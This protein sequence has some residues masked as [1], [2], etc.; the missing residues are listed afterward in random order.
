MRIRL[1][2]AAAAAVALALPLAANAGSPPAPYLV[3]GGGQ[4]VLDGS[5]SDQMGPGDTIAFI[6]GQTGE[7][8][9]GTGIATAKGSLQVVKTSTAGANQRPTIIFNGE[10]TCIEPMGPNMARF[11]GERRAGD[12]SIQF[13][14]VDV[15]D[16]GDE[17]RGTDMIEFRESTNEEDPCDTDTDEGTLLN[18]TTLARGNA[19][20]DTANNGDGS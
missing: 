14:V 16:T 6:A 15:T 4:V 19:K 17:N 5:S 13:F 11:G 10:V 1:V 8:D 20:V 3:T 12:N 7:V 9:E 18:G 2:V